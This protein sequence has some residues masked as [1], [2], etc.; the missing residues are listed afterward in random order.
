MLCWKI[1]VWLS[2]T[3]GGTSASEEIFEFIF[4]MKLEKVRKHPDTGRIEWSYLGMRDVRRHFCSAY[5]EKQQQPD[6]RLKTKF[7]AENSRST[8][9]VL[10]QILTPAARLLV[11]LTSAPKSVTSHIPHFQKAHPARGIPLFS[12]LIQSALSPIISNSAP[13]AKATLFQLWATPFQL[14]FLKVSE[15]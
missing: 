5:E 1:F 7:A 3:T 14:S 2:R 8:Q 4:D 15:Q 12:A 13:N 11:F 10:L 6:D 9:T